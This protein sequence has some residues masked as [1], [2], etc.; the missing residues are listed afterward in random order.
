MTGFKALP[1][2]T[3]REGVGQ[4]EPAGGSTAPRTGRAGGRATH[5]HVHVHWHVAAP[6]PGGPFEQQR[7]HA[8]MAEG[9]GVLP[10][11]PE[12]ADRLAA[13]LRARLDRPDHPNDP[14]HPNHPN[15]PDQRGA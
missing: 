14:D 11:D 6:P 5:V 3:A 12:H 10:E 4:T 15:H 1:L 2:P 7:F 13:A 9:A 8:L